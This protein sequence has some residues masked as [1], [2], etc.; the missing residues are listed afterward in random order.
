MCMSVHVSECVSVCV[1]MCM[2]GECVGV[3]MHE[4]ECVSVGKYV[5]VWECQLHDC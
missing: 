3:R 2:G 1:S 5:W 4:C